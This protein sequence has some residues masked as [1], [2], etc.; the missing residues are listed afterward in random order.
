MLIRGGWVVVDPQTIVK[1][2]A[3][4]VVDNRVAE[5]GTW[6]ALRERYPDDEVVGGATSIVMPGLIDAHS[7]GRGLSPIQ[8]G[9]LYDYLENA[10][11][12]WSSMV[13]LPNDLCAALSAVRHLRMGCTSIHHTGW[14]DEGPKALENA[15]LAIGSYRTSGIRLAY[16]P[17]VRDRNRFCIDEEGFVDTLPPELR[18]FVT[19]MTRYDAKAIADDY[20][21]LFETLHAS[22]NSPMTRVLHGPSWA[23]G[24]TDDFFTR[25]RDSAAAHDNTP[26]HIHTLQTPHQ[27]AWSIKTFGC[28]LVEH[29]DR[30]SV[31]GSNTTLGHAV[32]L[33][34]RDIELIAAR[35]TSTTHHA[36][37]NLHVRNGISPIWHMMKQGVNVALG[38]DD[39]SLNDDDDPFME[40][41]M[42]AVLSRVPGFD[43]GETPALT[44]AQIL[45]MGTV[46]AARTLGF[47]RLH[48]TL[49]PGA[50]ADAAILDT[51]SMLHDPWTSDRL[52]IPDLLVWR[53][54]GQ[55]VTDVVVDGKV[56][57]R[58]RRFTTMDVEALYAEVRD[59]VKHYEAKPASPERT[60]ALAALRPHFHAW[61]R[62]MLTHLDVSEPFYRV[63][64]RA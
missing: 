13:Y 16:S 2:A 19:P 5:V 52:A 30:L 14:N 60:A 31:L 36:S 41:R 40:L 45:S 12:D 34:E 25:I 3:I 64:G 61:H 1:D 24:T 43:L 29:L 57:I 10:F 32:W 44:S 49:Q 39:K 55:D 56:V 22:D 21:N 11:L 33:S 53:A 42:S 63:N 18:E 35:G 6:S 9:V 17:A 54:K 59:Y 28:S 47:D 15:H 8:K 38:I 27:R 4:H 26:I 50:P 7:H 20:M 62:K 46:N 51:A 48:G 58:D 37:C 23:H